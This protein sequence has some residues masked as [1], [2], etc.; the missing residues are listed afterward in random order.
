MDKVSLTKAR[1]VGGVWEGILHG[2]GETAP[3]L[4]VTH[5]GEEIPGVTSQYDSAAKIWHVQVPIPAE[6]ISDGVQTFVIAEAE[7]GTK[8]TSFA[9]LAGQAL[10]DDIRVEMD[11]LREELDLLKQAFR[12]HCLETM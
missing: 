12:R 3:N 6:R 2:A 8:L 7:T 5:E 1:M 11:L 4:R 9:I 10:A